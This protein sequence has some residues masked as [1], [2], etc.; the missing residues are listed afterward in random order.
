MAKTLTALSITGKDARP[1]KVRREIADGGCR[2]LYL[3]VFPN[4][5]RS[6]VF[7]YRFKTKPRKLTIGP[8]YLGADE[9]EQPM[10]GL[11]N[12]LAGARRLAGEAALLLAKGVDPAAAKLAAQEAAAK[13]DRDAELANGL[14]MAVLAK[15]FIRDHAM[16]RTRESSWKQTARLIGLEVRRGGELVETKTGGNVLSQWRD[17][18]AFSISRADVNELLRGIVARGAPATSNRVLAAIRKL[19]NWA[20]SEDILP[21][22]PCVGVTKKADDSSRDRVLS[23]PEL[24]LIWEASDA[25]GYPWPQFFKLSILTMQ[26]RNEVAEIRRCEVRDRVWT[27]PAE[28]S[29]NGKA[30]DVPLSDAALAI[31]H[32]CNT[33]GREGFFLTRF[34]GTGL[35]GFS[36]AKRELDAEILKIQA[37]EAGESGTPVKPLPRWTIHDF[38]RA[39]VSGLV[40]LGHDETAVDRVLNHVPRKLNGVAGIYNRHTYADQKRIVLAAWADHIM[41]VVNG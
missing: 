5:K 7:R 33:L 26:R 1:G 12:T 36:K 28:R 23:D 15:R 21:S 38:R 11:A 13:A 2:G 39:G 35:S 24:R 40:A 10:L 19:F 31:L 37:K 32:S 29:K 14:T 25:L 8:V 18:P 34:G 6:W 30:H 41:K 17:R 22:S 27:I 4:G 20:V 9:I 3:V 16:K